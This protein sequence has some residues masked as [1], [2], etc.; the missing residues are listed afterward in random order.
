MFKNVKKRLKDQRGLTLVELLA[1]IVILGIIAAI[2]I[3]SIGNIIAKSNYD[4]A[5][6]DA[7]QILAAANMANAAGE[8]E[9]DG[10]PTNGLGKDELAEYLDITSDNLED[11]WKVV[12]EGTDLK[13]TAKSKHP[14]KGK[15]NESPNFNGTR[16]EINKMTYDNPNG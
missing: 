3:P 14:A 9:K 11:G 8:F 13:L 5:K 1:V 12:K 15:G 2:A 7:L 16:D 10:V 6:A 4:A